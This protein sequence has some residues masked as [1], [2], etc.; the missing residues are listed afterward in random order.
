[1][2]IAVVIPASSESLFDKN[3]DKVFGGANVQMYQLA[4]ELG[5]C[6]GIDCQTLIED[7]DIIDFD[8]ADQ[9]KLVRTYRNTDHVLVK[10]WKYHRVLKDVRP[11]A[12]LQ[13]G[14]TFFSPL[15]ALYCKCYHIRFV[16]MFAHDNEVEGR[17]QENGRENP[18]FQ[19][20]LRCA[21]V[22]VTQSRHQRDE[23]QRHYNKGSHILRN[24]FYLKPARQVGGDC[25]LWVA[26]HSE[27]KR[28]EM[29]IQLAERNPNV[30]FKMICPRSKADG[31]DMLLERA[32]QVA[33][34]EFIEYVPFARIDE[35][36]AGARAFVN[37]SDHEGFPQTFIQATMNGVP[38]LSLN[39]D[40]DN[41]LTENSCGFCCLGNMEMLSEKLR[42][43]MDDDALYREMSANAFRYAQENHDIRKNVKEL[44]GLIR[45][46]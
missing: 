24:G 15:L 45:G 39:V 23:L 40:P 38:I 21:W 26:R 20:L 27:W 19:L 30:P 4:K 14:L 36:F 1:M 7:Y 8:E 41:I 31:Y 10:F 5:H 46:S 37:T 44:L 2:K 42:I 34:L 11:D 25:V 22:L 9:F 33:N 13:H 29:F 43:L 12:V 6:T 16:Y 17:Y 32:R 35:Y 28:P 3:C 18:L